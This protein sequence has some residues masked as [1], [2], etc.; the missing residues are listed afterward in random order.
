MKAAV[1]YQANT[2]LVIKEVDIE[3]PKAGEVQVRITA[4]GICHS[5]LHNIKG[6]GSRRFQPSSAMKEP[7]SSRWSAAE[8]RMSSYETALFFPF[9]RT[10]GAV[11]T[12]CVAYR[13]SA[14]VIRDRASS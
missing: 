8:I 7:G 10:A 5:D 2:P 14:R 1:L 6:S 12:A 13:L 3:G 11:P 9:D 4:T